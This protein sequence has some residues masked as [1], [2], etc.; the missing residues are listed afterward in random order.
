[1]FLMGK[2]CRSDGTADQCHDSGPPTSYPCSQRY[3]S[4]EEQKN[5][6]LAVIRKDQNDYQRS[7]GDENSRPVTES[8]RMLVGKPPN[9]HVV[10]CRQPCNPH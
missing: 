10:N 7:K 3:P 6:L 4:F 1:M 5:R 9:E 2:I 8:I